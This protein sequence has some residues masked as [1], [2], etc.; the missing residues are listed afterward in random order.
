MSTLRLTPEQLCRVGAELAVTMT[1]FQEAM[2]EGFR[3][4]DWAGLHAAVEKLSFDAE[5]ALRELERD[6][7]H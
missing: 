5:D 2:A 3:K 4:V 6:E 7:L 1:K